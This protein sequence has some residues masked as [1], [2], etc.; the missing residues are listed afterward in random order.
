MENTKSDK[1]DAII[2]DAIM[3]GGKT[4]ALIE[5]I[6]HECGNSFIFVT[7]YLA[8]I[9][10]I[11]DN[12]KNF[13][14]PRQLGKG[15]LDSL[16][17]L[18]RSGKNIAT[19][20][21]LFLNAT[22]ETIQ[23]LHEGGYTLILDE[24]ICTLHE[25]NS[26]SGAK[27]ITK[28]DVKWLIN[29]NYLSVDE[30]YH[31]SWSATKKTDLDFYYSKIQRLAEENTLKCVDNVLFWEY[32]KEVFQAFDEIYVL[33]YLFGNTE[34][35]TYFKMHGF[36]YRKMSV[37]PHDGSYRICD[38]TTYADKKAEF[39][40]LINI[41]D[42]HL[43]DIGD[44]N[45]SFSINWFKKCKRD[46]FKKINNTML[47]YRRLVHGTASK[48]MWTAPKESYDKLKYNGFK[49][50]R[51][52]TGEERELPEN[53]LNLLKQFV[54]CNARAT[55]NFRD[56][57]VLLYMMNRY[58]NPEIRKYYSRNGYDIDENI[59]AVSELVQWIWRSAIRDGKPI[60]LFIPSKRMRGLFIDWLNDKI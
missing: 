40:K 52:L 31:V 1:V 20:H 57:N 44:S 28:D 37:E 19:T 7:P 36:N 17:E 46:Q 58:L 25:Y 11:K 16:H 54:P 33:T 42:G 48:T 9:E 41:Y 24:A 49:Y 15:K 21:Q 51:Q 29:E 56:R 47:N 12:T 6:K 35:D 32:P 50:I 2:V 10:R 26:V 18:L 23:L 34:L 8:E 5:K 30:K 22:L 39:A 55:N 60:D 14:A 38:Y 4:S 53:Q 13:Y 27:P 3:G 45:G 43:N 59:F